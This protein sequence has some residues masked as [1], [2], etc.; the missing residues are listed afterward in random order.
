MINAEE[1]GNK[2]KRTALSMLNFVRIALGHDSTHQNLSPEQRKMLQMQEML[3]ERL[4]QVIASK[5]RI[6]EEISLSALILYAYNSIQ[7]DMGL[8]RIEELT[9]NLTPEFVPYVQ[10]ATDFVDEK[11]EEQRKY[12]QG[13][14]ED[15]ASSIIYPLAQGAYKVYTTLVTLATAVYDALSYIRNFG[16]PA[17][18]KMEQ[19][20][21]EQVGATIEVIDSVATQ[22]TQQEYYEAMKLKVQTAIEDANEDNAPVT[23]LEALGLEIEN[24]LL[25]IKAVGVVADAT[26]I[27]I[28][29]LL[30]LDSLQEFDLEP[31]GYSAEESSASVA[32]DS[33]YT[34]EDLSS[35]TDTDLLS[36]ETL[37]SQLQELQDEVLD[38]FDLDD[39]QQRIPEFDISKVLSKQKNEALAAREVG[40][41]SSKPGTT[42][43]AEDWPQTPSPKSRFSPD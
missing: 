20:I 36:L 37:E 12:Y 7:A 28:Q 19:S 33:S 29:E 40:F 8:P 24:A 13:L 23:I 5:S 38:L 3:L 30:T 22:N 15:V 39:M 26:A 6:K 41:A 16:K 34:E 9:A 43:S 25:Q 21:N 42:S 31:M 14:L 1:A 10:A 11:A 17:P 35:H 4:L 18:E 27:N 32:R 2:T